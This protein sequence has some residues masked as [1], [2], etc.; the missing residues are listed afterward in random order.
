MSKHMGNKCRQGTEAKRLI[1][2]SALKNLGHMLCR[3]NNLLSSHV[4]IIPLTHLLGLNS[5]NMLFPI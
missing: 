2:L 5:L 3:N 4:N 1:L